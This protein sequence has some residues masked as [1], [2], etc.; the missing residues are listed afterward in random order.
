VSHLTAGEGAADA[1]AGP[2]RLI[3]LR[4]AKSGYPSGTR[5]FDRPLADRGE[6]EAAIA[7]DWIR[8]TQ[9]AVDGVLC[10]AAKR[11]RQ[12]LEATGVQAH[13]EYLD[14]IYDAGSPDILDAIRRVKPEVRTLLVVGHAPGIPGLAS[15]LAGEAS[16]EAALSEMET[17]FPTSALAVFDVPSAWSELDEG[18]ATLVAYQIARGA[19]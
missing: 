15:M 18:G 8:A 19:D 5:D 14:E 10:S 13:A 2:R 6:T 9:P 12:T 1:A 11:T 3:L 17:R 16:D 4:H 7:G